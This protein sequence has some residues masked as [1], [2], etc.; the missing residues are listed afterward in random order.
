VR[1]QSPFCCLQSG[2]QQSTGR[3]VVEVEKVWARLAIKLAEEMNS[4][5]S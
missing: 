5:P 3:K 1:K 2:K 4:G